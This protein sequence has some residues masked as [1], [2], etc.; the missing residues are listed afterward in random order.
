[1]ITLTTRIEEARRG[2]GEDRIRVVECSG[3]KVIVVADG[4]GGVVG[5][6]DAAEFVCGSAIG[7]AESWPAW[8][9]Q[10]DT[11]LTAKGT[12]L[13]AA[14]VLSITDDGAIRGA[15]V[16]DCEAWV[17]GQGKVVDLTAGQS[18]K[19]LL[20]DGGARPVGFTARL[21]AGA[22]LIV[23]SDGL[24]KYVGHARI[25]EAA[26]LRPLGSAAE[27]LVNGA[28]LR[29]GSL[30]DDIAFVGVQAA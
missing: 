6:A 20:G 22:A 30:Q 3:H 17:F 19:P 8:L 23:A 14:V 2:H 11:V 13:A 28:R 27:A 16:G 12:G 10:V 24:W 4:A 1:M 9:A 15:S 7:N 26:A 25:V 18:R 29:S 21:E 5:G